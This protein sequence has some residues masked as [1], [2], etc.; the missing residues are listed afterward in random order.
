M[1]V[2]SKARVEPAS[3]LQAMDVHASWSRQ[4]RSS[5]NDRF[6]GLAFDYIATEFGE[7]AAAPVVDAGCGSATKSL[8]LAKRG[9]QVQALDFS[10]AILVEAR[11]ESEKAGL[12][13][14]IDFAQADL[15]ALTLPTASARRILCWGVLMHVPAVEKAVAELSRVLAPGGTL[16]VSEGNKRS[17]QAWGFSALKRLLGRERA[18]IVQ[19]PAGKEFWEET[20][21][22]KLMTRQADIPWLIAEF[23]RHGLR[24]RERRAGQFTEIYMVLPWRPLRFLVHAFNNFW[25][26]VFPAF[27]GGAYGNI[28]VFDR[29]KHS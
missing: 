17:I 16:I 25:F 10:E 28:L 8:H 12:A 14:R 20:R 24:L 15:T 23:E 29:P 9:F 4:F 27:A 6:Y 5:E 7:P 21:T 22:G 11:R 1:T 3:T 26:S 18:E 2:D 19:A 13:S